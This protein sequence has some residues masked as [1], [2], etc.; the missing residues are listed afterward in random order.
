MNLVSWLLIGHLVG[1]WLLQNDWMAR[2]KKQGLIT[3]A[4]MTH[5]V[6]YTVVLMTT[7]VIALSNLSPVSLIVTALVI[8]VSHWLID[9]TNVV[10]VWMQLLRQTDIPM[11]RIMVDQSFHLIVLAAVAQFL[12]G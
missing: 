2:G 7:V 11:V 12:A 1:D 6:I 10:D 4:G 3:A 5:F 8:F 9:A